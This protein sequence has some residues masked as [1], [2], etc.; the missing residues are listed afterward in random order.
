MQKENQ[1]L[2][3]RLPGGLEKALSTYQNFFPYSQ[4]WRI[5]FQIH[6]TAASDNLQAL[7]VMSLA[8]PR[9]KLIM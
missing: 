3:I 8:S 2:N 1:L 5:G 9:P 6:S 4:D 7:T